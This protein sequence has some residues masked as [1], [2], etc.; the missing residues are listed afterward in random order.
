LFAA[1]EHAHQDRC[2]EL[3]TNTN[4][5]CFADTGLYP[6]RK[7]DPDSHS[8]VPNKNYSQ[9][10]SHSHFDAYTNASVYSQPQRDS[11]ADARPGGPLKAKPARFSWRALVEYQ[12]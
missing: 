2:S 12:F 7:P 5:D 1:R 6:N 11:D 3:V 10:D 8:A 9:S 4:S